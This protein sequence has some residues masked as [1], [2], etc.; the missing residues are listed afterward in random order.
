MRITCVV[1]VAIVGRT[2]W[3]GAVPAD[4]PQVMVCMASRGEIALKMR[5]KAVSSGIFAGIGVKVLWHTPSNCPAEAIFITFSNNTPASLLPGALA[6]AMP[7]EGTH[8]VV[9]YDRVKNNPGTVSVLLGH[10]IAHEVTHILQGV[11]RHSE[12]GVMKAQWTG[13]D[14]QEMTWKPLQFTAEDV[15]LIHRGL[16][17]RDASQP[18]RGDDRE[19]VARK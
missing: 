6:Y 14:Y 15:L 9:F 8:I 18:S 4:E 10:V 19:S 7:Y 1:M 11:M 16:K 5:A 17:A 13:V 3:A 12:S 2:V